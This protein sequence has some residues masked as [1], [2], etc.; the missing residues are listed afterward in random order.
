MSTTETAATPS[1]KAAALGDLEQELRVSR[2]LLERV[3]E[4]RLDFKPH[5]KSFSLG[6]LAT[7]IANLPYW[8]TATLQS[9][10]FDLSNVSHREPAANRQELLKLFD[11]TAA[12]MRAA[13]DAASDADLLRTWELRMGDRVL[14]RMPKLGVIRGMG[15]S[16]FIH[17]RGQ[18]SVYLRL[19]DVPLPPMYGPTADERPSFG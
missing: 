10:S 1:L 3:P 2:S 5:E 12:D 6:S 19:L 17:H 8:I 18:L 9:D 16:H 14:Q 7:H 11:D 13:L 4:D 15:I